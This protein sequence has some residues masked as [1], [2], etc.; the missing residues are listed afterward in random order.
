MVIGTVE[1]MAPEQ[2]LGGEIDYRADIYASGAVL[3]E[4]VTGRPVFDA[5]TFTALMAKHLEEEPPD[6]RSLNPKVPEGLA[7]LILKALAKEPAQRWAS[8]REMRVALDG[9]RAAVAAAG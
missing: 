9:L 3:F 7:H 2:L 6:P 5:P 1:Y 4:C 8:A